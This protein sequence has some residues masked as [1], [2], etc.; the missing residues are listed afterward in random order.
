[1]AAD[2]E[3]K[4]PITESQ[5]QRLGF[6]VLDFIY[7]ELRALANEYL[8]LSNELVFK[9]LIEAFELTRREKAAALEA[10]RDIHGS[11]MTYLSSLEP[12]DGKG[13]IVELTG[14]GR[15]RRGHKFEVPERIR[16][17]DRIVEG[18]E[19]QRR[20]EALIEAHESAIDSVALGE[21]ELEEI[22]LSHRA[23]VK[24]G[25]VEVLGLAVVG[26]L[27]D[28]GVE[29]EDVIEEYG[30]DTALNMLPL[31]D[32]SLSA[33]LDTPE[34]IIA[35]IVLAA[36]E[37][38]RSGD[39]NGARDPDMRMEETRRLTYPGTEIVEHV[40]RA[41][42]KISLADLEKAF[43]VLTP[44]EEQVLRMRFG[45]GARRETK[46]GGKEDQP[47]VDGE[48]KDRLLTMEARILRE[49]RK[50]TGRVPAARPSLELV[51]ED[52]EDSDKDHEGDED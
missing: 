15:Q 51:R 39:S 36:R 25:V 2:R 49:L 8:F 1:M 30:E 50:R 48:T 31:T 34:G 40:R 5:D 13:E 24:E 20:D 44:R 47:G 41:I 17:F 23:E 18:I 52:P 9:Q 29:V 45:V 42:P 6:Y 28:T 19:A 37:S 10:V 14:Q 27:E 26:E 33:R 46:L 7:D 35:K 16:D 4:S 22:V 12:V 3:R 43:E 32:R 38:I 11:L 21:V